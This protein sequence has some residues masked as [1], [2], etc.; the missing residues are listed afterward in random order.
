MKLNLSIKQSTTL[1]PKMIQA[2]NVLQMDSQE[3]LDY[4]HEVVCDNPVLDLQEH[5]DS[6]S[7][8]VAVC[9]ARQ[10]EREVYAD[11]KEYFGSSVNGNGNGNGL[12]INMSSGCESQESLYYYISAQVQMLKLPLELKQITI[13]LAACLDKNG[14]LNEELPA[15]ADE[16]GCSL[17]RAEGAL[18]VL[19]SLQPAGIGA[20]NL[21]ECLCLQL[22]RLHM[23][24]SVAMKIA[25]SQLDNLARNHY[26]LIAKQIDATMSD[27]HSACAVIQNLNPKPGSAFAYQEP[28]TY[29]IPDVIVSVDRGTFELHVNDSG[30]PT[31]GLN[32]YYQT[33]LRETD[34]EEVKDYL[35]KKLQQAKWVIKSIEQRHFT[36]LNCARCIVT[37][38]KEFFTLGPEHLT[39]MKLSDL[40]A[41]LGIHVSTVSRAIKNKYIQCPSGV[42][43]FSHFFSCGLAKRRTSDGDADDAVSPALAK[44][45]IEKL[46]LDEDKKKPLS[47]QKICDLMN[48][49]GIALSRRTVAKYRNELGIPGTTG[50]KM[51]KG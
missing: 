4:I 36:L 50:R 47:D 43:S 17:E 51:F 27:V 29:I 32:R 8:E 49:E 40:S 30:I 21:S 19:Q 25:T 16:I 42:Y 48:R 24:N 34:S 20:R 2:L 33:L 31:L 44:A 9:P 41:M 1:S 5:Y 26:G 11:E 12:L 35:S 18:S 6:R 28:V 45:F 22:K 7:N 15:L 23:E 13:A 46:I 10:N 39:P 38:Q 3:L 14:Y 37:I